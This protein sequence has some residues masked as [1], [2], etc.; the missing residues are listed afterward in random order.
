MKTRLRARP[1]GSGYRVRRAPPAPKG[2]GLPARRSGGYSGEAAPTCPRERAGP[3][4]TPRG[5]HLAVEMRVKA[6]LRSLDV[7]VGL[8]RSLS[9]EESELVF[10][11][12]CAD[13]GTAT[14][15]SC[16][17]SRMT[18]QKAVQ[19]PCFGK[20]GVRL[21][22]PRQPARVRFR[23][24]HAREWSSGPT[25]SGYCGFQGNEICSHRWW[26]SCLLTSNTRI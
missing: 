1:S 17:V 23:G 3:S 14:D 18:C 20:L 9:Y 13:F 4:P 15:W 8:L 11:A 19:R 2:T 24:A 21:L 7:C 12:R 22:R 16:A 10:L 6:F 26:R 5:N 25:S